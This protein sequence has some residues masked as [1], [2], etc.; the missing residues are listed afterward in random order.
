MIELKKNIYWLGVRDWDAQSFHGHEMSTPR[1]TSYNSYVIKDKK[2]ALIDT[3][4][5]TKR[6]EYMQILANDV[7]FEN[8]DL[9]VSN[10]NEPDHS[11]MLFEVLKRVRK[12]TPVY[13]T[14]MGK[15]FISRFFGEDIN[16][17]RFPVC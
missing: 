3:C 10:H 12:D 5:I 1:G 15:K 9:I 4:K 8:I 17:Q 11:G 2:T 13:C 7:G 6:E 14:Q 16:V